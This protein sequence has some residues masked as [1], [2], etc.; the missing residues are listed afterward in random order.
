[1]EKLKIYHRIIDNEPYVFK[2]CY[3]A[4]LKH[5]NKNSIIELDRKYKVLNISDEELTLEKIN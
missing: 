1:M 3:M 2:Y 4:F 5:I